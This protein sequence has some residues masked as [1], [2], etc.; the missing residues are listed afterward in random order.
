MIKLKSLL[1]TE[2]KV[3]NNL[4]DT[5]KLSIFEGLVYHIS[6]QIPLEEN[7][8]RYESD[9]YFKLFVEARKMWKEG[10]LEVTNKNDLFFLESNLGETALYEGKHVY[11]DFPYM[12]EEEE[13]KEPLNQPKRGGPKKF[14]VFV[15]DGDGVKKV[16]F[17]DTTGLSVKINDLEASKAFAA[18][19]KC[20]QEKDKTS[21][22]YWGCHL[23]RYAKQLG[24][25]KPAYRYW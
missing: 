9:N 25:G 6:K 20:D 15:K 21:A 17:G 4:F 14:Y 2:E 18:R 24:L 22:N 7:I 12:N 23:P 16:T 10:I 5:N 19:H 13:K 1:H 8:Y 3:Q 11:L